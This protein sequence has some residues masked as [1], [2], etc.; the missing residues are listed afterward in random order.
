MSLI[1][2]SCTGLVAG[3]AAVFLWSATAARE[4]QAPT[5]P[6]ETFREEFDGASLGSVWK[7]LKEDKKRWFLDAGK[8]VIVTQRGSIAQKQDTLRNQI[9]LDRVLPADYTM[10]TK[11]AIPLRS[12]GNWAG[13]MDYVDRDNY[14]RVAYWAK[15]HGMNLWRK[16]VFNKEI[17][18]E[19][20]TLEFGPRRLGRE[21]DPSSIDFVGGRRDPETIW[22]RLEKRGRTFTGSFSMDGAQWHKIGD[23]LVPPVGEGKLS[24]AAA[25]SEQSID[26]YG[27]K[28]AEVAAQFDFVEVVPGNRR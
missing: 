13:I 21:K 23:H 2:R 24:L 27:Q 10:T 14:L 16:A 25:N 20:N 8:L 22:L 28:Q 5:A 3:C 4:A 11:L 6:I 1:Q 17:A 18:S 7:I 15:P 19:A 12:Q 9:I 26:A